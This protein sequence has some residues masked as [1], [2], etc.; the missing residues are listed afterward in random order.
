MSRAMRAITA[1]LFIQALS[2]CGLWP[3]V[4]CGPLDTSECDAAAQEI[5]ETFAVEYPNRRIVSIEFL[6]EEGH[7]V[8]LLDDGTEVGFGERL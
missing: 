8:V 7:A 2:G 3:E 4:D 1:V 5:Q 6:N